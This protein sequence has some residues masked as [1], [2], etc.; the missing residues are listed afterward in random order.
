MDRKRYSHTL[1]LLRKS[2]DGSG[3]RAKPLTMAGVSYKN[4]LRFCATG[5]RG[6]N[7]EGVQSVNTAE[8]LGLLHKEVQAFLFMATQSN[9]CNF[10]YRASVS[11]RPAKENTLDRLRARDARCLPWHVSLK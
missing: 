3:P 4:R 11:L 2:A 7:H 1:E 6:I 10:A 9:S 8:R 5:E